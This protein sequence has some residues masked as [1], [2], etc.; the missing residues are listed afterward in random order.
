MKP[1]V[2]AHRGASGYELENSLAAFRAAVVC[3]ADGIELDVHSSADHEIYVHHDDKLAA[4]L[5]I[6][7]S[8]AA[9]VAVHVLANGEPVPTLQQ[10]LS[11]IGARLSV[12]VE[13]KTMDPAADTKLLSVLAAGPN[14]HGYAI[15]SFDHRLVRRVGQQNVGLIRG[16]LSGSYA[17]HPVAALKDTVATDLWQEQSLI[18]ADLVNATHQAHAR[19]IAWT[20]NEAHRMRQLAELGVDGLC[21]NFPDVCRATVDALAAA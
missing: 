15:H 19:L 7:R 13:L 16:V 3:G 12:F 14:P 18:D 9:Q 1:L 11:A 20:V 17:I 2:I 6:S 8:T 4:G 21:T 10:A 5:H